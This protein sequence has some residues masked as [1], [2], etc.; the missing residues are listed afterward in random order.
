VQFHTAQIYQL[1]GANSMPQRQ[2]D[3]SLPLVNA[4]QYTM[5]A[6]SVTTLVL[7]P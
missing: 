1:T 6:N 2:P 3:I 4:F 7:V 5:P